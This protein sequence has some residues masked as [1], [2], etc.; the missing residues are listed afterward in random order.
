M[1]NKNKNKSLADTDPEFNLSAW[2]VCY[3]IRKVQM[4]NYNKS[5]H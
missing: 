1:C 5:V 4:H 2:S 3:Q